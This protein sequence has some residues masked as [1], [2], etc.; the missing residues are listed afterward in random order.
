MT[1][2]FLPFQ[3]ARR[4]IRELNLAAHSPE[5]AYT[6]YW[7]ENAPS[8]LPRDPSV[9]YRRHG[10]AGWDDFVGASLPECRRG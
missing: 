7:R 9:L 6:R 8:D 1:S 3:E 10:W 4:R 2:P 5:A